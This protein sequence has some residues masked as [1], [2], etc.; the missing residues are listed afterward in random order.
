[1]NHHLRPFAEYEIINTEQIIKSINI[2]FT[3]LY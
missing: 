2:T 3:I 1:M